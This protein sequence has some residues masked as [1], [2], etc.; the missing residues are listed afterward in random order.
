MSVLYDDFS[1]KTESYL[2]FVTVVDYLMFNFGKKFIKDLRKLIFIYVHYQ[3]ANTYTT[4]QPNLTYN[5]L[6][7]YRFYKGFIKGIKIAVQ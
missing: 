3:L 4:Q 5:N 1:N 7:I 2:V 6:Y